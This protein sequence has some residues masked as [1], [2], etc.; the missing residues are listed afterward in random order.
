[1]LVDEFKTQNSNW[2]TQYFFKGGVSWCLGVSPNEADPPPTPEELSGEYLQLINVEYNMKIHPYWSKTTTHVSLLAAGV[3]KL[4]HH[5]S[6]RWVLLLT[7][8]TF[9]FIG[10]GFELLKDDPP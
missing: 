7:P 8:L 6:I 2:N 5:F 1:M 10:L 9:H 4:S 3:I